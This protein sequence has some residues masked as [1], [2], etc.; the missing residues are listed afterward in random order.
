MDQVKDF[1]KLAVKYRFW[2]A[3]VIAFLLPM[4]G[5]FVGSGPVKAKAK[6][7][8]DAIIAADKDVA[9]YTSPG[10]PNAQYK[11]LVDEKT[12][13]VTADVDKAWEKLY[14]NQAPLLTWPDAP[15][16]TK[17]PFKEWGRVLPENV[18]KGAIQKAITD[19]VQVYE[20]EVTRTYKKVNP[21]M[22]MEGTGIVVVPD[23]KS[24]LRPSVFD[25][26]NPPKLGKVWAAQERL[27]VQGSVLDAVAKINGDAK[28]W[29][30][31]VVKQIDLLDIGS[32]TAQ[33]QKSMA[34]GEAVEKA[35]AVDPEE[36]TPAEGGE[37]AQEGYGAPGGGAM[38][39]GMMAGG[40][41]MGMGS[42]GG[43]AGAVE[44]MY[45]VAGTST[46]FK[47]V[48]VMM[49]ALVDQ[50]RLQDF[51]IGLE[52]SPLAIQVMEFDLVKPPVPVSKPVKGEMIG[53]G[54]MGMMGMMG[55]Y[56]GMP[57]GRAM[58]MDG[59]AYGSMMGGMPGGYG[60]MMGRGM[61]GMMDEEGG[62]GGMMGPGMPGGAAKKGTDIRQK[63]MRKEREEKDK[64]RKK[65]T[66]AAVDQYYDI[67][68][69]T[70]YGRARFYNPPGAPQAS[71]GASDASSS[72]PAAPAAASVPD[73]GAPA[74][75]GA[76]GVPPSA[77]DM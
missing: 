28:D 48:P 40:M 10:L 51:F 14:S 39:R 29:D 30:G 65:M 63:D 45:Y 38:S 59:G 7:Q 58:M 46:Q 37:G 34:D 32:P 25:A 12:T 9:N 69:V 42:G 61:G 11:P 75:P 73:P 52:N 24:F 47:V 5:Y 35:P 72:A 20:E 60:G 18:D 22:P 21:W 33:D 50:N 19:Y 16:G 4:I 56:G 1:L 54:M 41:G 64:A 44:D 62:Y 2:I 70:I 53:G 55:G 76:P 74:A 13:V 57:G 31:A 27:W 77:E 26:T 68:Q 15:D 3:A 17:A 23:E 36:E 6:T 66:R 71:L 8:A 67:V 49:T 43:M